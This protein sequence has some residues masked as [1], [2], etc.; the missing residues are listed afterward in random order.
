MGTDLLW[1]QGWYEADTITCCDF[2]L[3]RIWHSHML[4][5]SMYV[6]CGFF[7]KISKLYVYVYGFR[8]LQFKREGHSIMEKILP[9]RFH[10]FW[11]LYTDIL[12][13]HLVMIFELTDEWNY[14]IWKQKFVLLFF[15]CYRE[16]CHVVFLNLEINSPFVKNRLVEKS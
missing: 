2:G 5:Y 8:Y 6:V 13:L 11:Y 7:G 12:L 14:W 4:I 3:I 16:A 9:L 1:T 15:S 10:T